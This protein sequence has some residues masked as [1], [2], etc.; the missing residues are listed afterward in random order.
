MELEWPLRKISVLPDN[1][2]GR[3]WLG[4]PSPIKEI[5]LIPLA[6]GTIQL[7]QCNKLTVPRA[8]QRGSTPRATPRGSIVAS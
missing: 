3:S 5:N 8:G 4:F 6:S 7:T 2:I 1:L